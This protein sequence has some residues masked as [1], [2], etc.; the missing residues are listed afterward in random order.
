MA[1]CPDAATVPDRFFAESINVFGTEWH[2]HGSTST[3]LYNIGP[4]HVKFSFV[5]AETHLGYRRV[6]KVSV[7][8][9]G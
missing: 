3:Y 9:L 2:W 7:H 8:R 6:I 1:P 4:L 5:L